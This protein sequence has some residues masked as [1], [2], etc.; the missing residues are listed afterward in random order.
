MV[1]NTRQPI[2]DNDSNDFNSE[3]VPENI[4]DTPC[5]STYMNILNIFYTNLE[6]TYIF[7]IF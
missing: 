3:A 7:L 2:R 1:H 6:K 5:V 4:Y